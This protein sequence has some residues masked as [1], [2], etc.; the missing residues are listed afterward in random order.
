MSVILHA[1]DLFV[2]H[3]LIHCKEYE[4]ESKVPSPRTRIR[5]KE[6]NKNKRENLMSVL[7]YIDKVC[8]ASQLI[9]SYYQYS[10]VI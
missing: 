7:S 2:P 4:K 10:N 8:S 5:K 6:K 3:A 9:A 1:F